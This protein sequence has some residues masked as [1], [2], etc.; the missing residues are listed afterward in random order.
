MFDLR[1]V[2]SL[3]AQQS[4]ITEDGTERVAQLVRDDGQELV[5]GLVGRLRLGASRLFLFEESFAF[6]LGALAVGDV[7][8]DGHYFFDLALRVTD[9]RGV[10]VAPNLRTVLAPI[11]LL[12]EETLAVFNEAS[13]KFGVVWP[14]VG[15]CN[16]AYPHFQQ[17]GLRVADDIAEALI[18]HREPSCRVAFAHARHH[19]VRQSSPGALLALAQRLHGPRLIEG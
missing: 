13:V 8:H 7:D 10:D 14:V 9:W 4:R 2:R 17:F 12:Y 19:L 15:V 11:T 1:H 6:L 18:D 5:F 16:V 3:R